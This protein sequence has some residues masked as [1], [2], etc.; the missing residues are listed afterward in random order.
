MFYLLRQQID[1]LLSWRIVTHWFSVLIKLC[2]SAA[3]KEQHN[4]GRLLNLYIEQQRKFSHLMLRSSLERLKQRLNVSVIGFV[5]Q[6]LSVTGTKI[7]K[8]TKKT[9][10]LWDQI[11]SLSRTVMVMK[12][13]VRDAAYK[14]LDLPPHPSSAL[15]SE[16]QCCFSGVMFHVFLC[17]LSSRNVCLHECINKH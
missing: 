13:L 5:V 10:M 8:S 14:R 9:G 12:V 7:Q 4:H 17:L 15:V 16:L 1:F 11:S 2:E 6:Q 3:L